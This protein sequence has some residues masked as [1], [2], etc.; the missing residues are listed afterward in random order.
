MANMENILFIFNGA[1]GTGISGGDLRLF[2]IIKHTKRFKINI[3]T[4]PN[5]NE[6]MEKITPP[7]TI[8]I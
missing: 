1:S 8:N 3:L 6:L 5:G 4:T 2:E 7:L